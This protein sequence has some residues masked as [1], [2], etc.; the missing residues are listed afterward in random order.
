[1]AEKKKGF[2]QVEEQID[3]SELKNTF[4]AAFDQIKGKIEETLAVSAEERQEL[5]DRADELQKQLTALRKSVAD[6]SK[7]LDIV[8]GD[9]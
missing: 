6:I 1:M 4:D 8:F 9:R 3:W 7:S 5:Q 2:E